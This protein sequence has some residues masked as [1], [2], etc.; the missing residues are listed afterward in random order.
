MSVVIGVAGESSASI[1]GSALIDLFVRDDYSHALRITTRAMIVRNL[2]GPMFIGQDLFSN[3]DL[4][5][6]MMPTS[7]V[8]KSRA[9]QHS[10]SFIGVILQEPVYICNRVVPPGRLT[11][12]A[13][14][15]LVLKGR[16]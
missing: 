3:P 12:E 1:R 14:H 7:I 6:V 15:S 4:Y 5:S 13:T 10:V 8:L 16:R 11:L 9:A 2:D